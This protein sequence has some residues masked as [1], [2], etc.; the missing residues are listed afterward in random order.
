MADK[1]GVT[2]LK[3]EAESHYV[4]S[5]KFDVENI[6]DNLLFA[7]SKNCA[8][9]KEAVMN[10]IVDN[11][12]EIN[13]MKVLKD[14]LHTDFLSDALAV[15]AI[16]DQKESA[17]YAKQEFS[18]MSISHLRREAHE[19]GLGVDGTRQM[20]ISTLENYYRSVGEVDSSSKSS[21]SVSDEGFDSSDE[22]G[23]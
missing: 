17:Y 7:D 22:D 5:V 3:L 13:E 21:A 15:L 11:A 18:N 23:W 8:L 19:V 10:F 1:Y 14:L 9:L 2:N 6:G 20:L 12:T 4:S 16:R